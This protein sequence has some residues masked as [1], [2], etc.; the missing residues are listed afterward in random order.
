M[1]EFIGTYMILVNDNI[2]GTFF[3]SAY[4]RIDILVALLSFEK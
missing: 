3:F 2:F 4:W 1:L